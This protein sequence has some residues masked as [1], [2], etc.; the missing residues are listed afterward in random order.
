[1]N[2]WLDAFYFHYM[3]KQTEE[4]C[5]DW[6]LCPHFFSEQ[7]ILYSHGMRNLAIVF[8]ELSWEKFPMKV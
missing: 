6:I 8:V 7:E 1:M 4:G 5:F 2:K 3:S